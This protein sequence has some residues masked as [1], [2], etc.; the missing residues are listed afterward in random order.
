MHWVTCCVS[1]PPVS[2][3]KREG[4][5]VSRIHPP[6]GLNRHIRAWEGDSKC[7]LFLSP[8]KNV[9]E[10]IKTQASSPPFVR[11]YMVTIHGAVWVE[12]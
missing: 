1:V 3:G 6:M 9:N 12:M 4:E 8:A 2:E 11:G 7:T 5:D 10:K